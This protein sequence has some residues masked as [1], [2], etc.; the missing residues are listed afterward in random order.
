MGDTEVGKAVTVTCAVTYDFNASLNLL[1]LFIA[2]KNGESISD[3]YI[4]VCAQ[5]VLFCCG[6]IV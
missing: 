5:T 3:Q 6:G 1:T 2:F 4:L